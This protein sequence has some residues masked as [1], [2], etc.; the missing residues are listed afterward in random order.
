MHKKQY[1]RA[2]EVIL[3]STYMDD[4][5]DSVMDETEGV[6]LY[7]ELSELW[8]KAGMQTHK[9]LSNS[10]K[11]LE[12][13]PPQYRAAEVNLDD[14][15]VSP[16]K[17]LGILWLATDDVFTFKSYCILEKFQPTKRNFLKRIATLFDLTFL[18]L[19]A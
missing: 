2:A 3:K 15:G 11:V 14:D 4:S 12:N 18:A 17:I 6:E 8:Q 13:I 10:L 1:P 9:W 16:V 7:K 5:M 19:M